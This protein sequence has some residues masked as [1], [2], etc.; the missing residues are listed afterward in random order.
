MRQLLLKYEF[1]FS[2]VNGSVKCSIIII[3]GYMSLHCCMQWYCAHKSSVKGN[4][5]SGL[6]YNYT[7]LTNCLFF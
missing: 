5:T 7:V 6:K 3:E 1:I 2:V 4:V